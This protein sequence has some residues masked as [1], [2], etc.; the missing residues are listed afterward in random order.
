MLRKLTLYFLQWLW[1]SLC[2]VALLILVLVV[3]MPW[4]N[5][6]GLRPEVSTTLSE[7]L[8]MPLEINGDIQVELIP[9]PRLIARNVILEDKNIRL[10]VD[11]VALQLAWLPLLTGEFHL[12][13]AQLDNFV[14]AYQPPNIKAYRPRARRKPSSQ[15][16]PSIGE[17][18]ET[19]GDIS[20]R[21]RL[22]TVQIRRG[23]F[24]IGTAEAPIASYQVDSAQISAGSLRGPF[25][26]DGTI[27][28]T[29]Y[30]DLNPALQEPQ[31][32]KLALG[33]DVTHAAIPLELQ[34][35]KCSLDKPWL[36]FH[37]AW[38]LRMVD[39]VHR[40]ADFLGDLAIQP[41]NLDCSSAA[42]LELAKEKLY[43]ITFTWLDLAANKM[44]AKKLLSAAKPG[45]P[46]QRQ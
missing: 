6:S 33:V 10:N 24:I 32:F 29:S 44:D 37:G 39:T 26:M 23:T 22:E 17:L 38:Q 36:D 5:W 25:Q 14:L 4:L 7:W 42:P 30:G 8:G 41:A 19:T 43:P 31:D 9:R 2:A 20:E 18:A 15:P 34:L 3:V 46:T 28:L 35:A 45:Q 13:A 11:K 27:W 16:T 12:T 21:I 40:A 1:R